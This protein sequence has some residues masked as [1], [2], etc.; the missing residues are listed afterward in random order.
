L[1]IEAMIQLLQWTM[2]ENR[3]DEG[4]ENPRFETLGLGEAMTWRY[5]GQV[6]PTNGVISSTLEITEVRR[7]D[8]SVLVLC[9]ASLWVDGKRIYEAFNLGMR[10]V[11]GGTP[12][13]PIRTLD[14]QKD[15]WLNDHCPTWTAPALPMMSMV[16][17]LAQ[18]ACEGDPV[19]AL[20][21]VRVTGWLDCSTPQDLFTERR[22]ERVR[23]LK[24]E[25]NGDV[26][27]VA[28]ATVRT[29]AYPARPEALPA[30][31]G[32][33]TDLPYATGALFHGPAFQ[34]LSSLIRTEAGASSVLQAT[35]GVP[36][37]RLN[38]ALL[39]GATHGIPHD[40]LN[41]WDDRL[42]SDKVA[43]PALITAMTFYGPTP[44]TGTVRCEVRPDGV[45]G[46]PDFP[47]F[48]VQLIGDEGVWCTFRLIESCFPKGTLGS[49]D[50]ADRM[51]FLKDRRFVPGVALGQC[52]EGITRVAEADVAQVDW[53]PGTVASLYGTR[54][55]TEIARKE[56]IAAA[57]GIHPGQLPEALPLQ[58]F[59]LEAR[60]EKDAAI[61]R[62]D[63]RGTLDI[64]P[65]RTFWSQWFDRGPWPVE[66]LYYG[67]I[68]QFLGRVVIEDPAS[69]EAVR[70]QSVLY[71]GNHQVGV[72]SLLFAIIASALGEVPTVTLAKAEHRHTW[73]GELIAHCF[74]YPGVKDPKVIS[75]FD[76]KD[77]ASLPKILGELAAEMMQS[78]RSVMVHVEGTR[79]LDCTQP[80]QKMSGAFLDM[81]MQVGAP[82]VPVRFV[83]ALPRETLD[84]RI[85]FPLELGR[86][87]I[88]F[89]KPILPEELAALHY[90]D[91]KKKV[92]G[93]INALGPANAVE[94][95]FKGDPDFSAKVEAWQNTQGVS[96]EHAVLRTVLAE[97]LHP[98]DEVKH[99]LQAESSQTLE[100]GETG[101]WLSELGRRL[102]GR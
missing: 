17:L 88:Y 62:G 58:R 30:L 69:F 40:Q 47:A 49:A 27:E 21:D 84:A 6:I 11:S 102:I 86:Q 48:A 29:G 36:L 91:R 25:A 32:T 71:L 96:H 24:K 46:S 64:S 19:T 92:I 3:L 99:L 61:V 70:G 66:D 8:N 28:S 54:D 57:H 85:E 4:I 9:D 31:E 18:G 97:T 42:P 41:L 52:E 12:D 45:L 44:T 10:I 76:R 43:Y 56:H 75:F 67:L 23:L 35:S 63:G 79:S 60:E 22:G 100:G 90:G 89:G 13:A 33:P 34:V 82:V 37:G 83:G 51:A 16:D 74:T 2:L 80:V 101:A 95:P 98:A 15:T 94:T 93:A 38:P 72:E 77:K 14:P 68:N 50:P 39:D 20:Q 7:E 78:E 55:I 73:L 59:N 81:A 65:I 26:H 5:R 87:D 1:G 53:L